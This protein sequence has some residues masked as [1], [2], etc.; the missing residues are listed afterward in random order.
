MKIL[1][2]L[3]STGLFMLWYSMLA[4]HPASKVTLKY[5]PAT[6]QVVIMFDH[7]VKDPSEHFIF[8]IK[9]ELNQKQ[10]IKQNLFKQDDAQ[11][12]EV[13]YRIADAKPRDVIK[14]ITTCNKY[15]NQSE[16]LIIPS[17]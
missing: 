8:E 4:A 9:V 15:G 7:S 16:N 11:K 14:V 2:V 10:I 3:I 1:K 6:Q 17:E 12:G 13:W 5:D